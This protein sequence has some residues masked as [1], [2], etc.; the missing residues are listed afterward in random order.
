MTKTTAQKGLWAEQ[1]ADAHFCTKPNTIVLTA[2]NG[3]GLCDFCTINTATGKVQ[4][5][6]VKYGGM[7]FYKGKMR[8][9]NRVAS[10]EQKKLKIKLIYVMADGT[11][12]EPTS[13]GK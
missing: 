12:H 7:R 8:L 1:I 13:R 4:K 11:V 6:D 9:I 2:L 10:D 5:Y 3:I